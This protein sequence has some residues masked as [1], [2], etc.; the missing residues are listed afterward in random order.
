[1]SLIDFAQFQDRVPREAQEAAT[2]RS[3]R[4]TG[5]LLAFPEVAGDDFV[6]GMKRTLARFALAAPGVF[7]IQFGTSDDGGEF[8]RLTNNFTIR[9]DPEGHY[10]ITDGRS[11]YV[12]HGPF[13]SLLEVCRLITWLGS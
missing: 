12:D 6:S 1:M 2:L 7:P 13:D 8:C 9:C 4:G 5:V 10:S 3:W 11:G